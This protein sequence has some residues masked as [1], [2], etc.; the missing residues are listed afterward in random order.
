MP[1]AQKWPALKAHV[2]VSGL[3]WTLRSLV[4][5]IS[6]GSRAGVAGIFK[7]AKDNLG[8]GLATSESGFGAWML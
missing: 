1:F 5:H 2:H 6:D 7:D 8:A 3:W 4:S